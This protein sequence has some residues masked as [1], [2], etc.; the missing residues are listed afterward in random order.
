[1]LTFN[2][3]KRFTQSRRHV[4]GWGLSPLKKSCKPPNWIMKHCKSV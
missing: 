2:N 3:T 1:M 4:G